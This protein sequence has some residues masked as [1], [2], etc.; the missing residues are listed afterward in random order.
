MGRPVKPKVTPYPLKNGGVTYRVRVRANGRQTTETF[1]S[2]A[3]ANV[4]ALRCA[5]LKVGPARAVALRAREDSVSSDYVPTL[6]EMVEKHVTGL[7]GVE[8]RTR[9]DYRDMA[10]R[11][12]LPVIGDLRVDELTR[13][14]VARW[15]NKADGAMAPKSI[16]NAHGLLSSVMET[17][18][19][20]GVADRNPAR[21]T[22]LPRAGE[23][24]VEEHRY[25][26]VTEFDRLYAATDPH[27][28]PFVLTLFGTGMRFSEATGLQVRDIDLEA[29]V[30]RVVRAWKRQTRAQG[31]PKLGPPKSRAS[32]RTITLPNEVIDAL[33]PLV[34]ERL[35]SALL[36]TTTRGNT[37]RHGNF[38]NRFWI[39]ACK[40]AGL[41]PRP[42]IHDARH[43][44]ASWLIARGIRL[45]VI[46]DRLGHED[47]TTTRRIYGHLMP[48]L[49][50]EASAAASAAFESTSLRPP[51]L[52]TSV[53]ELPSPPQ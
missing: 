4:F 49:R 18:V 30:V 53:V 21:R 10:R 45:E 36:F 17:A 2:E 11:T 43:S 34:A 42:R 41:D 12:W 25:L 20:D 19:H 23:E 39:T 52:V 1:T 28:Q 51:S 50:T 22:R 40:Q 46:Q 9:D 16:K 37:V 7:T 6:A 29:G 35:G 32:R 13:D 44:H 27:Y 48:D 47:Y 3:A 24:D 26:T 31:G 8:Q 5:D 15:V 38:Y 14:D 33:R